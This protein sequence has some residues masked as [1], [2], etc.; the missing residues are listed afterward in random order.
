M[1]P[2]T[3][4]MAVLPIRAWVR[5]GSNP[6]TVV[7]RCERKVSA[8]SPIR[9]SSPGLIGSKTARSKSQPVKRGAVAAGVDEESL[10]GGGVQSDLEVG[11]RDLG[12][13]EHQPP[14]LADPRAFTADKQLIED[15]HTA[16]RTAVVHDEVGRRLVRLPARH[17][18]ESR[19]PRLAA[20]FRRGNAVV[21]P[22]QDRSPIRRIRC[23]RKFFRGLGL[24]LRPRR[25][26]VPEDY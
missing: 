1:S 21:C 15:R 13:E 2:T 14:R 16:F 24:R 6:W 17:L 18:L 10:I 5:F 11:P 7:N 3:I 4:T 26:F 9:I 19:H 25:S 23:T 20:N 8:T 12:I 22:D